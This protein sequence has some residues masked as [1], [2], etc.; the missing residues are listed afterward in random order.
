M[1]T[2]EVKNGEKKMKTSQ[3]LKTTP[4]LKSTPKNED[5]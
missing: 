2:Y 1:R 4:K 3:M 5:L